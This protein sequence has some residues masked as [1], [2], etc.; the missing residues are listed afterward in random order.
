MFFFRCSY[1][2]LPRSRL[3]VR[4][5]FSYPY[6]FQRLLGRIVSGLQHLRSPIKFSAAH[7]VGGGG[8]KTRGSNYPQQA[9]YYH[10]AFTLV[11]I[12]FSTSFFSHIVP[13]TTR[14]SASLYTPLAMPSLISSACSCSRVS[15]SRTVGVVYCT[16]LVI[17]PAASPM[18]SLLD[19]YLE[20]RAL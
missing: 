1:R 10:Q 15:F 16:A 9:P 4:E 12:F 14:Y 20:K 5:M 6:V 17:I 13:L 3:A 2:D 19:A 7:S 8:G 18:L 11:R